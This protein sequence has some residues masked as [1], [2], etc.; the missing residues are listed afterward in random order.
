MRTIAF[1]KDSWQKYEHLRNTNKKLHKK[2]CDFLKEMQRSNDPAQGIGQ[3]EALKHE[4]SGYYSRQ[5]SKKDRL[6]YRFDEGCI[7]IVSIGGHYGD[8]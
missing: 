4:Y 7:Y 2:L 5:L 8:H 1:E 6:I 3:P